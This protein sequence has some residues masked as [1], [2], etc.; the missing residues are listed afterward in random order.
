MRR[1]KMPEMI[2][3][4]IDRMLWK[5]L[6]KFAYTQSLKQGKRFPV[7]KA[8]RLA[9]KIFLRLEPREINQLLKRDTRNSG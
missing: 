6:T 7:I 2:N 1:G 8:L 4:S 9:V 5:E 3:I